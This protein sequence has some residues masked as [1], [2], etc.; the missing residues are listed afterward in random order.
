MIKLNPFINKKERLIK[1]LTKANI[2]KES[3]IKELKIEIPSKKGRPK[4][5]DKK[6]INNIEKRKN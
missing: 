6:T 3:K 1:S 4:K 5:S 2:K